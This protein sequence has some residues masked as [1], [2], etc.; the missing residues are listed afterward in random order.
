MTERLMNRLVQNDVKIM[1]V[2][3]PTGSTTKNGSQQVMNTP[4]TIPRIFA[5]F[6]SRLN[7]A[8]LLEKVSLLLRLLLFLCACGEQL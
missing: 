6:F 2:N 7:L 5:A 1:Q 3:L 4:T 8:T